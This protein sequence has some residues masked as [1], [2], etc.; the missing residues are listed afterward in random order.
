MC[1]AFGRT[2]GLDNEIVQRYIPEMTRHLQGLFESSAKLTLFPPSLAS[3]LKLDVWRRFEES[4]MNALQ[5]ANQ[6]TETCLDRLKENSDEDSSGCIVLSLQ[7]QNVSPS[8][9]QRV[10]ADL[11]LAAADTVNTF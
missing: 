3:K 4:A 11:F 2:V 9:I 5:I 8:D 7:Q 6:L 1:M 10:V